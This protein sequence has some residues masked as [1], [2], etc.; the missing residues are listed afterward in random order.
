MSKPSAS[1]LQYLRSLAE[2]TG[3]TFAY[4]QTFKQ[5][6]GEIDRLKI[7]AASTHAERRAETRDRSRRGRRAQGQPRI[8]LARYRTS[9]GERI[10][11]G[12]RVDGAVRVIDRVASGAGRSYVIE[13]GLTSKAELDAIVADYVLVS[14]QRD[15]PAVLVDLET[16]HV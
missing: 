4:P 6:R 12:Q 8:E 14:E 3:S 2:R 1:Q 11:F 7:L 13:R 15:H 5:A 10:L 9:G 16:S